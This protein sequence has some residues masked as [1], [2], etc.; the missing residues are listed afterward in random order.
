MSN[1][2]NRGWD[3]VAA[4]YDG[5]VGRDGSR[6]H[7]HTAIPALLD[8]LALEP[9]AHLLDIGAGTGVLAAYVHRA[10]AHYTGLEIS[11]RLVQRA[12]RHHG[13][14]ARFIQGD[15][16]KLLRCIQ[17]ARYDACSF[18]LSLQDM[19]PLDAVLAGA[20]AALRPGGVLAIVLTHP[21]FRVPRQSGW[22]YE[23]K[24]RL[25]YRRVD[26]YLSTK[27]VPM[28]QHT[29]GVTISFHRPLSTYVNALAEAGLLLDRLDE[30]TTHEHVE[31]AAAQ[32]AQAE[33]PLFLGLRARKPP[34]R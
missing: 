21:C 10:G 13:R 24:R 1:K 27:A 11:P 23:A 30:L 8:L 26:S 32:R 18:L 3:A 4:W 17:P 16:R 25:L 20:N 28:K 33:F 2:R 6:H 12:R 15:A 5:W 9:S 14:Y 29:H 31:D 34:V 22:G 7:Q 19:N